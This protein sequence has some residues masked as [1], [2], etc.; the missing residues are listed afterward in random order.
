ML[1]PRLP[2]WGLPG[3][4]S[5]TR[6]GSW[7]SLWTYLASPWCCLPGLRG[8]EL[9]CVVALSTSFRVQ[10]CLRSWSQIPSWL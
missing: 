8:A 4:P 2:C 10:L 7:G 3:H 5:E 1:R 9:S 6:P